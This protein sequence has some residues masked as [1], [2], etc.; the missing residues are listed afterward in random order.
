MTEPAAKAQVTLVTWLLMKAKSGFS[1]LTQ[2]ATG[3]LSIEYFILKFTTGPN[4]DEMSQI[5]LYTSPSAAAASADAAAAADERETLTVS[6]SQLSLSVRLCDYEECRKSLYR[7]LQCPS[8]T[9]SPIAPKTARCAHHHT[10]L[11]H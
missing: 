8:A 5:K 10:L 6:L 1:N 3:K 2:P 7:V 4:C 9:A 11:V